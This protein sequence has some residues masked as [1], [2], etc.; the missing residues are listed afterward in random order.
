MHNYKRVLLTAITLVVSCAAIA[1]EVKIFPDGFITDKALYSE[2]RAEIKPNMGGEGN[3]RWTGVGEPTI[4]FYRAKSNSRRAKTVVVC[5]GGGYNIISLNTEGTE[6]CEY[7][8]HYGFNAVLL[9]YRVPRRPGREIHEAPLEDVQRAISY[10]RAKAEELE[11]D[12]D[13]I[14][15]IGFSAGGHLAVMCST[16]DRSYQPLD[17]VD[18]YSCRPAFSILLYPAYLKGEGFSLAPN[19]K[20]SSDTPP[21]FISQSQNDKNC[22]DGAIFYYYALKEAG[23]PATMHIYPDGGHGY[24]L[25]KTGASSDGW[26]RRLVEWLET[27]EI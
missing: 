8:T 6:I 7:L 5:P 4:T 22:V 26:E 13:A 24:G 16:S 1:Q 3:I 14:G 17:E 20:V 23:V 27:L 11:I 21:T 12:G 2:Y 19:V 9:K 10:L 15:V 18:N 25:R